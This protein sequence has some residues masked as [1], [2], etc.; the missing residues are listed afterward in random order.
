MQEHNGEDRVICYA[1]RGLTDVERRYPQTEKEALAVVW[2][3]KRFHVYLYGRQ[4]E[5]WTDHKPLECIYSARSRPSARI[6]RGVLRLQPY[7][8]TV[9]YMPGRL[10]IA[11]SLSLT[12]I[13][14]VKSRNVTEDYANF[15]AETAVPKA[16]NSR[17]IEV[18]LSCDEE[19]IAV[20]QSIELGN[21]NSPSSRQF[22]MSFAVLEILS[23][24]NSDQ[25]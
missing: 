14:G 22:V 12:K 15:V 10:N 2:L 19:L 9:K 18:A 4:F 1:S 16:M 25:E 8:F 13:G 5:L 7:S 20:R 11:D 6:E 3:C 24:V 21:W 23:D 17:E